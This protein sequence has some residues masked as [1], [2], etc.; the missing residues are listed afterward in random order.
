VAPLC[1]PNV[2]SSDEEFTLKSFFVCLLLAMLISTP[3]E[4]KETKGWEGSIFL[5]SGYRYARSAGFSGHDFNQVG[6]G[7]LYIG[8]GGDIQVG[9]RVSATVGFGGA[10]AK[11]W[12][13]KDPLAPTIQRDFKLKYYCLPV[14]LKVFIFDPNA[15]T[16]FIEAGPSI[17]WIKAAGH[18]G[19]AGGNSRKKLGGTANIGAR[20]PVNVNDHIFALQVMAGYAYLKPFYFFNVSGFHILFGIG[21][22]WG[23]K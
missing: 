2:F 23:A 13:P 1:L 12:L 4:G 17:N 3:V 10:Q 16:V 9:A 8:I 20:L 7:G 19:F 15:P 21:Y 6:I 22:L 18:V 11:S 5:A 14:M